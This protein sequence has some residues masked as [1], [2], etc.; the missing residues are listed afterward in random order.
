[1]FWSRASFLWRSYAADL[2]A[3]LDE[4]YIP[5]EQIAA[6]PSGMVYRGHDLANARTVRLKVLLENHVSCPTDH[7]AVHALGDALLALHHP[8]IAALQALDVSGDELTLISEFADGLNGWGFI[9]QE[10]LS[11]RQ[12]N[13]VMHQLLAALEKGE[14]LHFPHGN[15]KPSNLVLIGPAHGALTLKVLDWGLAACR[16]HQP[17]ETL[18]FRAPELLFGGAANPQSDLFS[19]GAVV[20]ALLLG[21]F[22]VM[23]LNEE[24][25][26]A[27]WQRFDPSELRLQRPDIGG[28]WMDQLLQLLDLD[29]TR[30]PSSAREAAALFSQ[31]MKVLVPAP[32]LVLP[33]PEPVAAAALEKANVAPVQPASPRRRGSCFGTLFKSTLIALVLF[34]GASIWLIQHRNPTWPSEL[35]LALDQIEK[36]WQQA[37]TATEQTVRK[38][39]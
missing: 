11:V 30:R 24:A 5:E 34:A 20:A 18:A 21:R 14:S 15:L 17:H 27:A 16:S 32:N 26:H 9:H 12:A 29:A 33:A 7:P 38:F 31:A 35:L 4:P 28:A 1:M 19:A 8:N 23:G 10:S 39:R 13:T 6:G 37:V 22:P 3:V 36:A 2:T 25:L